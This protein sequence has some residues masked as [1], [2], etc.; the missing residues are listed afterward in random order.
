MCRF[1]EITHG[2]YTCAVGP[3]GILGMRR[4]Y[5]CYLDII[6]LWSNEL[7]LRW[8]TMH[9]EFNLQSGDV[10]FLFRQLKHN[11]FDLTRVSRAFRFVSQNLGHLN[12]L[13]PSSRQNK[14]FG[15]LIP[16]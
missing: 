3:C 2:I 9:F 5:P 13:C 15:F 12:N 1:A 11:L 14:H 16:V 10:Y 4:R 6:I 7:C 8:Q